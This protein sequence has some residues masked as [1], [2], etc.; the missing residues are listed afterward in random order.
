MSKILEYIRENYFSL[1]A[2]SIVTFFLSFWQIRQEGSFSS[3]VFGTLGLFVFSCFSYGY[4]FLFL[5]K[6]RI[7]NLAF[8]FL[9]GFF[10]FNTL[11]FLTSIFSTVGISICFFVLSFGGIGIA[12]TLRRQADVVN[13]REQLLSILSIFLSGLSATIWCSE[14]QS[15]LFVEDKIIYRVWQDVFFHVREISAFAQAKGIGT[16]Q[17][18]RMS[19]ESAQAYHFAS[20]ISAAAIVSL[21]GVSAIDVYSSFQLPLGIFLTGISAFSLIFSIWGGWPAI[22]ATVAILF[23]PDAYQQGFGNKYLSY[24]FL[25]Q[26]NLGMLYGVA[27]SAVAW[28]FIF[29]GCKSEKLVNVFVGYCFLV[30]CLFYKAH[31]F[32]ANAFLIMIYP[33][34]FFNGINRRW[35]LIIGVGL[36]ATFILVVNVSQMSNRVPIIRLDGSGIGTYLSQLLVDFDDGFLKEFFTSMMDRD[37]DSKLSKVFFAST[38]LLISTLGV[39][40][41]AIIPVAVL[42]KRKTS[43]VN[44]YFPVFVIINYLVMTMG[45]AQDS[46]GIGTPDELLNR[47]LVWAYFIVAVWVAG[48]GYFVIFGDRLPQSK[49]GKLSLISG[50]LIVLFAPVLFSKNIQTFQ[51][52]KGYGEYADFNSVPICQVKASE[53][54]KNHSLPSEIVQD[55]KNDRRFI[56][57]AL[58]ERQLFAGESIFSK[59]ST[60]L[61]DRLEDLEK[62]KAMR[63]TYEINYFAKS[64]EISWYLL[65]PSSNVDWPVSFNGGSVFNCEGYRVF[66]LAI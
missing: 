40:I 50:L 54:I 58:T 28:M 11:L 57:T 43:K 45:L 4:I 21:T 34:L 60:E 66:K 33:C 42:L 23:F 12:L 7:N 9:I 13:S 38:M 30:I 27:C 1:I 52:R 15:P 31:I 65:H 17:D 53:Y 62:F 49:L 24:N 5:I 20:Y 16:L 18:V 3:L 10:S 51:S 29:E 44:F 63:T 47:P 19:G 36:I 64:K 46:R 22:A 59:P 6:S 32:V 35:R 2:F 56:F 48:G 37:G 26:I 39:W 25:A 8:K 14:A 61:Q 55:S 41:L